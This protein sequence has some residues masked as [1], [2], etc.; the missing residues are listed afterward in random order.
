MTSETQ[1]CEDSSR[2]WDL[3][4]ARERGFGQHP[5]PKD[6]ANLGVERESIVDTGLEGSAQTSQPSQPTQPNEF[7]EPTEPTEPTGSTQFM[8]S[9][10]VAR[11]DRAATRYL[12]VPP[13]TVPM[14]AIG[15]AVLLASAAVAG[16]IVVMN[17]LQSP[18][19]I[20]RSRQPPRVKP[21]TVKVV[22]QFLEISMR[23]FDGTYR[24]V[25][26]SEEPLLAVPV[27]AMYP[28]ATGDPGI[29]CVHIE[30]KDGEAFQ[31]MR[32]KR[33]MT[34]TS[35]F[36]GVEQPTDSLQEG[37]VLLINKLTSEAPGPSASTEFSEFS[38]FSASTELSES[39]EVPAR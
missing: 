38:E 16:T 30:S 26:R 12:W 5:E 2:P 36:A 8:Q 14:R 37:Q 10:Q 7:T 25:K 1:R 34:S 13:R 6:E 32:V 27:T 11:L 28:C 22:R 29:E 15:A 24:L 4:K 35:G 17:G 19:D 31:E 33:I 21:V 39:S 9:D 20:A 3:A 18:A 23:D